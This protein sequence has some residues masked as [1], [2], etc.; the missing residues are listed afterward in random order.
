MARRDDTLARLAAHLRDPSPEG[1]RALLLALADVLAAMPGDPAGG[2]AAELGALLTHLARSAPEP[3]RAALAHRLAPMDAAPPNLMHAFAADTMEVAEPVLRA[4]QGFAPDTLAGFAADCPPE[5]LAALAGR[6]DLP[7]RA[8]RALASR[9][10]LPPLLA[11]VLPWTMPAPCGRHAVHA[12]LALDAGAAGQVL[13]EGFADGSLVPDA[14]CRD[15]AAEAYIAAKTARG[16]LGEALAVRLL[17]D[18]DRPRFL[19]CLCALTGLAPQTAARAADDAS[20]H[21]FAVMAQATGISRSAFSAMAGLLAPGRPTAAT[22]AVLETYETADPEAAAALTDL[23]Q[24]RFGGP[25]APALSSPGMP[26]AL[27]G[28]R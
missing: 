12:G 26:A 6:A 3:A 5:H 10:D 11:L 2:R 20:G 14:A 19:A 9:G 13:R 15:D 16:E 25:D 21:A 24:V 23:W 27:A 17:R 8:A 22:F 7:P 4:W 1:R 28:T 18:G